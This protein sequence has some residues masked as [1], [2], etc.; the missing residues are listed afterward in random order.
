MVGG[1]KVLKANM[2]DTLTAKLESEKDKGAPDKE[3]VRDTGRQV[4]GRDYDHQSYCLCCWD[5]GELV[6]CDQCPAAYHPA[7]LV[8]SC[9][10]LVALSLH[11]CYILVTLLLHSCYTFV[12]LLLHCAY[13]VVTR[14]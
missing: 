11:F 13:T 3:F 4:A 1:D 2:Y 10:T 7:C 5:G 12:T 6:L 8:H 9:Y 14:A